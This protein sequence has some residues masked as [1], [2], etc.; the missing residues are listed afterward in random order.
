[1]KPN[2]NKVLDCLI[3]DSDSRHPAPSESEVGRTAC[4]FLLVILRFFFT[5]HMKAKP[6]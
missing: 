1:M 3:D 4:V 6:T 5:Y 2:G